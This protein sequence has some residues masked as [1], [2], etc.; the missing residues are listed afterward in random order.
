MR[1]V[2][3]VCAIVALGTLATAAS[4]ATPK[5]RLQVGPAPLRLGE[6]VPITVRGTVRTVR[7]EAVSPAGRVSPVRVRPSAA[8]VWRGVFRFSRTGRWQVRAL[9][10]KLRVRVS[11][12]IRAALPTP[13]PRSFGPLGAP[14]CAPPSPR[15]SEGEVFGTT[16]GGRFWAL[17]GGDDTASLDGVVGKETKIV[18]KL[19]AGFPSSFYAVAPN[20]ARTKPVSGPTLHGSSSWDRFG[21]EWGAIFVFGQAGCWRIHASAGRARGDIFIDVRS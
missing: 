1:G 4:P 9:S 2:A 12:L 8:D 18:F 10:G 16:V 21:T 6:P 15:N 11:V 17:L 7:V 13:P 20:G 5:L 3:L 14:G 19:D